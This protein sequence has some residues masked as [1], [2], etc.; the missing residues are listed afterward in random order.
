MRMV[1]ELGLKA[2]GHIHARV[3]S[4]ACHTLKV[5]LSTKP[6]AEWQAL[7]NIESEKNPP[8]DEQPDS[9]FFP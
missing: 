7:V 5:L 9:I 6:N 3:F 1:K 2:S 4:K 8:V